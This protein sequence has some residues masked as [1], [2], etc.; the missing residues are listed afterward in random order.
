[1]ANRGRL[2]KKVG[3]WCAS[4]VPRVRAVDLSRALTLRLEERISDSRV[5]NWFAG[6]NDPEPDL[7]PVLTEV[8]HLPE[9]FFGV[10]L[11]IRE[12]R[13]PYQPLP[14]EIVHTLLDVIENP[15]TEPPRKQAIRD[16][17]AKQFSDNR[18][19]A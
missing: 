18:Q 15:Q 9:D 10:A 3:E 6:L 1:M 4:R 13:K 8:L 5:R 14:A 2:G 17:L 16:F 19:P 11:E 7:W 12:A